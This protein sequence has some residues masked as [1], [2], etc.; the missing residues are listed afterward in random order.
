LLDRITAF[1]A[2]GSRFASDNMPDTSQAETAIQTLTQRWREH[3]VDMAELIYP[4][5]R[6]D[7][8]YYL[9]SHGW[10]T[11]GTSVA[12]L[13]VTKGLSPQVNDYFEAAMFTSFS[14]TTATRI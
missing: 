7:V 1:S 11:V 2:R 8:A 14:Y 5:D 6:N 9:D 4:G 3:G 10:E 12:E 13:F